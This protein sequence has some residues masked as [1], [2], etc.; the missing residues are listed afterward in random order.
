[1]NRFSSVSPL[2]CPKLRDL[3]SL[4]SADVNRFSSLSFS[5]NDTQSSTNSTCSHLKYTG[6]TG[7]C[8]NAG[9]NALG[10]GAITNLQSNDAAKV[11]NLPQYGHVVWS[12]PLQIFIIIFSLHLIIGWAPAL[13]GLSVTIVLVPLNALVGRQVSRLRKELIKRTDT[14]VKAVSEV[15]TGAL[16]LLM[17]LARGL[18]QGWAI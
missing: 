2:R 18:T 6:P 10:A 16:L 12:G 17:S 13:A 8:V 4:R 14:R 1:M 9:K 7:S 3:I 11:W 15:I 5:V